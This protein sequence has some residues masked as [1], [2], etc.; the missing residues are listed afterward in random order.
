[1]NFQNIRHRMN[2]EEAKILAAVR[3]EP[4]STNELS[5]VLNIGKYTMRGHI[6]KL[7]GAG[8]I[9]RETAISNY[10]GRPHPVRTGRYRAIA[11]SG[12]RE[13]KCTEP[14]AVSA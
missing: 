6:Q 9:E 14:L 7:L 4:Q 12:P 1:V 5:M 11:Q 10:G 3:K 8:R 13:L 2:S